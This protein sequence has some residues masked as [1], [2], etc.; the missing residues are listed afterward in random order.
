MDLPEYVCNYCLSQFCSDVDELDALHS[1]EG[2]LRGRRV[3]GIPSSA[4]FAKRISSIR[5]IL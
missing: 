5:C 2:L 4:T 3:S 1:F